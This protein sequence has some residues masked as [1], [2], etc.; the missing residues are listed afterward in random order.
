M[1][2]ENTTLSSASESRNGVTRR[3]YPMKPT[4]SARRQSTVTS[5]IDF[6]LPIF[7]NYSPRQR[8]ADFSRDACDVRSCGMRW[9]RATSQVAQVLQ[10]LFD[11]A[12]FSLISLGSIVAHKFAQGVFQQLFES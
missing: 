11:H 7:R 3:G 2:S 10:P 6:C 9:H 12:L 8:S 1:A 5:T 4:W